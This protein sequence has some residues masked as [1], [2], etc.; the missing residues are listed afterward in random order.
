M[1]EEFHDNILLVLVSAVSL[2]I[3]I[4]DIIDIIDRHLIYNNILLCL[5]LDQELHDCEKGLESLLSGGNEE[6][7]QLFGF[8]RE[9]MDE[10]EDSG[11]ILS[12]KVSVGLAF[13][14]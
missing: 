7:V 9:K 5:Q 2:N 6:I 4:I 10:F 14:I 13:L 8:I 3:D 1:D 12:G 11:R